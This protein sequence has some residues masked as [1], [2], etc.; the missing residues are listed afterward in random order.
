MGRDLTFASCS[1]ASSL[2]IS[3]LTLP[4]TFSRSF[5]SQATDTAYAPVLDDKMV[6]DVYVHR[7]VF[8]HKIVIGDRQ[9]TYGLATLELTVNE[10]EAMPLCKTLQNPDE[11]KE[12]EHKATVKASFKSFCK[13]ATAI[14]RYMHKYNL[15][16]SNC[17]NF[18]LY[19]LKCIGAEGYTP[20]ADTVAVLA[21]LTGVLGIAIYLG[22]QGRDESPSNDDRD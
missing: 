21:L 12:L 10:G 20:T 14:L 19:F 15:F 16:G 7:G 3:G 2:S 9:R 22:G 6:F 18:C 8:H 1:M 5:L 13:L 17:Q 11:I 4:I